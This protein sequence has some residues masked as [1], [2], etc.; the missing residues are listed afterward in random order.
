MYQFVQ[1]TSGPLGEEHCMSSTS[2]FYE[3]T[4]ILL[5]YSMISHSIETHWRYLIK[6]HWRIF[7]LYYYEQT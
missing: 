5:Y 6:Y 7:V 3:D 1:Y 2:Y 4:V